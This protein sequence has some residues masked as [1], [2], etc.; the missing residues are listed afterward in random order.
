MKVIVCFSMFD[1]L[2]TLFCVEIEKLSL[3]LDE[4]IECDRK[5]V[6]IDK[7]PENLSNYLAD[8]SHVCYQEEK[9]ECITEQKD[10]VMDIHEMNYWA[11]SI[12]TNINFLDVEI[13]HDRETSEVEIIN[14]GW[15]L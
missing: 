10:S 15:A 9:G 4:L 13:T 7:F 5:I 1:R 11:N 3:T 12:I 14:T 6:N 8:L 2:P